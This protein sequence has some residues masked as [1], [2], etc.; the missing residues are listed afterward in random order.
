MELV[1]LQLWLEQLLWLRQLL[2]LGAER[3][4]LLRW[5]RYGRQKR[6]VGTRP[7]LDG[8]RLRVVDGGS[9]P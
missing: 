7:Q 6:M 9:A 3:L 5:S 2:L 4:L 8:A 1:R